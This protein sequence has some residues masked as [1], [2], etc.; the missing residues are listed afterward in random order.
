MVNNRNKQ[1]KRIIVSWMQKNWRSTM[2]DADRPITNIGQDRL[3]RALFAKYLARSML[4]H[5]DP[6]SLVVGLYGGFG[7]GKTSLINLV[8][9]ELNYAASNML[10]EEKPII[11]SF[12]PWSY[13]GQ[14][15]LIYNFFRRLSSALRSSAYLENADR[16]IYLLEL[17][18]SFF[19]QKP[20]PKA[21]RTKRIWLE[22]LTKQEE[23]Y[24]WESGRDLTLVK[25]ELNELLRKQKHKII[26]IIDNIARLYAEEIKQIFQIVKS[27]GDYNNTVYLLAFD[28]D[29]V[30]RR[31]DQLE[32]SGGHDFVEKILQMPFRSEEHTS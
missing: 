21:F 8:L 28:K 24:G 17:Y 1:A 6:E 15:Q 5:H 19:T 12:S 13:S 20:I 3:N 25:A 27:M 31:I 11:L 7:V 23:I 30:I 26:V 18:V 16:I 10:E 4:D 22:K 32:G 9:E 14:N 29:Q 2:F